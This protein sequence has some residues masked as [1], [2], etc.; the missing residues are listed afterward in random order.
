MTTITTTNGSVGADAAP[1]NLD[2]LAF[3]KEL[4]AR[5]C[6]WNDKH[7]KSTTEKLLALLAD[8]AAARA[9]LASDD[10]LR[11]AFF[12][13]F[14]DHN[15]LA[16]KGLSLTSKIVRYV[17]RIT[18]NRASAYARVIDE[19]V[20][21]NIAPANLPT[22]VEKQGGIEAVRRRY[23]AGESPG[24]KT[25]VAVEAATKALGNLKVLYTIDALPQALYASADNDHGYCLALIRHDRNSGRGLVLHGS[26]NGTL[27]KQF[28]A[29]VAASANKVAAENDIN[30]LAERS[31]ALADAVSAVAAGTDSAAIAA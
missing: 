12:K 3:L 1:C 21:A 4:H 31:A 7:Y 18:G 24:E 23:N 25:N 15:E 22:W 10:D 2:K 5:Q 30:D 8:C 13:H 27:I 17:F 6:E 19:S 9:R 11:Q 16:G 29:N 26:A 14:D 28:L 20:R